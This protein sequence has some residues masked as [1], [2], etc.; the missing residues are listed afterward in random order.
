MP[1]K[2]IGMLNMFQN[3][4]EFINPLYLLSS[5]M[6]PHAKSR[7][8]IS[9]DEQLRLEPRDRREL[10]GQVGEQDHLLHGH[11]VWVGHLKSMNLLN[12]LL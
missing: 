6:R 5:D 10:H 11:R 3:G 8:G 2:Y 7:C 12:V 9:R 1:Y 4:F